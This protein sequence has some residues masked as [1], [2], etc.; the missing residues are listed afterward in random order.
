MIT[1]MTMY[2]Q[3]TDVLL[4]LSRPRHVCQLILTRVYLETTFDNNWKYT[5]TLYDVYYAR[6]EPDVVVSISV[7]CRG[8]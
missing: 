8:H 4:T 2:T 6:L 5:N 3:W 7:F 1:C